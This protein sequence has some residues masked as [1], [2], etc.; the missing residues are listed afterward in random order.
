M[1]W[2]HIPWWR[3]IP[4]HIV[5]NYAGQRS[6]KDVPAVLGHVRNSNLILEEG[7][8]AHDMDAALHNCHLSSFKSVAW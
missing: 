6:M 1:Y 3:D 7:I 5:K 8:S 4:P 2:R